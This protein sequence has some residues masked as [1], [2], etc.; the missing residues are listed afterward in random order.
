MTPRFSGPLNPIPPIRN[1]QFP[2]FSTFHD[3]LYSLLARSKTDE[4][5][6]RVTEIF[7]RAGISLAPDAVIDQI[8]FENFENNGNAIEIL[9]RTL[10]TFKLLQEVVVCGVI[11]GVCLAVNAFMEAEMVKH[12]EVMFFERAMIPTVSYTVSG[13]LLMILCILLPKHRILP[14]IIIIPILYLST[15]ALLIIPDQFRVFD[16]CKQQYMVKGL[17]FTL[18]VPYQFLITSRIRLPLSLRYWCPGICLH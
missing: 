5:Q 11:S 4:M 17:I 16:S 2:I 1:P 10:K 14:V 18:S 7:K 8:A 9:I 13:V 6:A 15:T 12:S 3:S